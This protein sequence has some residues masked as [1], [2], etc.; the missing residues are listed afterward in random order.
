MAVLR[1]EELPI[2]IIE[3]IAVDVNLFDLIQP[4]LLSDLL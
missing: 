1:L 3:H 4:I 2:L